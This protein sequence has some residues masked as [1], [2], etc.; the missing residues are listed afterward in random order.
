MDFDHVSSG[1]ELLRFAVVVLPSFDAT[2]FQ[3]YTFPSLDVSGLA[4]LPLP[5]HKGFGCLLAVVGVPYDRTR[6][7]RAVCLSILGC[8]Y[9]RIG[10]KVSL[11]VGSLDVSTGASECRGGTGCPNQHSS[12]AKYG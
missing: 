3:R 1:V 4:S 8:D 5:A 10:I 9:A 7:A 6:D 2:Y 12:G 11:A